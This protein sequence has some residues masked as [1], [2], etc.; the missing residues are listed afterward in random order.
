M[1]IIEGNI[2]IICD[3]NSE[4]IERIASNELS[5]ESFELIE[6]D[7]KQMGVEK[8]HYAKFIAEC[9]GN[10]ISIEFNLWEYPEGILNY[11]EHFEKGCTLVEKPSFKIQID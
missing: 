4:V 2:K 11:E 3:S 7:D 6:T 5:N 8:H 9:N 10:E 1:I